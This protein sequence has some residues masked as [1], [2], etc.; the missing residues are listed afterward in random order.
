MLSRV[1]VVEPRR[2]TTSGI[3]GTRKE[4]NILTVIPPGWLLVVRPAPQTS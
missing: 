1:Q 4:R 3:T 2:V